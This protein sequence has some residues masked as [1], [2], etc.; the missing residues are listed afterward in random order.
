MDNYDT[1]PDFT[2]LHGER[3]P[4]VI[5]TGSAEL[6]KKWVKNA[7]GQAVDLFDFV[8]TGNAS[9]LASDPKTVIQV[10]FFLCFDDVMNRF[11]LPDYDER[12]SKYYE[13][14]PE[15]KNRS[16]I[17]KALDWFS[18]RLQGASIRELVR[19]YEVALINFIPNPE[20]QK[21]AQSV[22]AKRD[23][24]LKLKASEAEGRINVDLDTIARGIESGNAPESLEE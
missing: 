16:P 17:Q 13:F 1:I 22:L 21:A 23:E 20:C 18:A 7:D 12:M 9:A 11:D 24:L 19:A 10:A 6:V 8:Q 15:L 2:D 3:W 4:V 5:T 14:D